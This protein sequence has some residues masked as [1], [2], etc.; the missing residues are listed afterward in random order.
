MSICP[1]VLYVDDEV[2]NCEMMKYYLESDL[3]IMV[4][5]EPDGEGAM[6]RIGKEF[7][8]VYILDYGLPDTTGIELCKSIRKVEH[9][10]K[11]IIYSAL[12]R[13]IDRRR[14]ISAGADKYFVKP[15]DI[16]ELK[17]V[18]TNYLKLAEASK[19]RRT[20][21]ITLTERG[22]NISVE[23]SKRIS[24]MSSRRKCS[25]IT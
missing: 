21:S 24:S 8:D 11:I 12:D 20:P 17:E 22:Q 5:T 23:R 6:R 14:A 16:D 15:D 4:V 25:G 13:P 7:F 19:E 3:P 9:D 1:R 18:V 2:G 10:A